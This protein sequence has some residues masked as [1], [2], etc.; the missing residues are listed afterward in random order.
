MSRSG[1]RFSPA[2]PPLP[3]TDSA[4]SA[5]AGHRR[6]T[7][8]GPVVLQPVPP[9]ALARP[10]GPG[11]RLQSDPYPPHRDQQFAARHVIEMSLS[12]TVNL[13]RS[14]DRSSPDRAPGRDQPDQCRRSRQ[15]SCTR[16]AHPPPRRR[17]RGAEWRRDSAGDRL[18][19]RS[20]T[21]PEAMSARAAASARRKIIRVQSEISD[22]PRRSRGHPAHA[23]SCS[24]HLRDWP[25]HSS[26][27]SHFGR[28]NQATNCRAS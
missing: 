20:A 15:V 3:R 22:G 10:A 12:A 14:A 24:M 28:S 4:Y 11:Y 2:T 6:P 27:R 21:A 23:A 18:Q 5:V 7:R 9:A 13:L 25:A 26:D 17:Q 8:P 1:V 16:R 19:G